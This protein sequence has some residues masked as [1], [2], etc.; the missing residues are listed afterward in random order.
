[1]LILSQESGTGFI[2]TC[3][4]SGVVALTFDDGPGPYT[5]ILLDYL[6][7]KKIKATFFVVGITIK[8][9]PDVLK[10]IF[11]DG[12]QIGLHT[13]THPHLNELSYE[14][15]KDEIIQVNNTIYEV[16]GVVPNY[17][18]PPFGECNEHC[19]ELM[20]SLGLTVTQWNLD[21]GDWRY[22]L[23]TSEEQRYRILNNILSKLLPSNSKID[24]F[25]TLQHDTYR[26][27]VEIVPKIVEEFEKKGYAFKT[28]AECLGNKVLPYKCEGNK[29]LTT[30]NRKMNNT[31]TNNMKSNSKNNMNNNI[32]NNTKNN[33]MSKTGGGKNVTSG[34]APGSSNNR[35][36]IGISIFNAIIFG[37][38]S[39]DG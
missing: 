28:V 23:L 3:S 17:M 5:N 18:R 36:F 1:M 14:Q 16:V 11:R 13:N 29:N 20:K 38:L 32:N 15:Q 12:H 6:S 30:K 2:T 27:S 4:K 35:I 34:S 7:K 39:V 22:E 37:L 26:Y 8:E 33:T 25:I 31:G 9:Y 19:G 21:S 24:S 10:R